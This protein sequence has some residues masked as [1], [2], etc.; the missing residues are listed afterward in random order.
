MGVY[1]S[2]IN[3]VAANEFNNL[4]LT[5]VDKLNINQSRANEFDSLH[6]KDCLAYSVQPMCVGSV[7]N[8]ALQYYLQMCFCFVFSKY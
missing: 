6:L 2:V 7:K 3:D 8:M 4:F 1:G 5:L